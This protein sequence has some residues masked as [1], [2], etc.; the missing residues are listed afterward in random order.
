MTDEKDQ[1]YLT[2]TAYPP[3]MAPVKSVIE[4]DSIDQADMIRK[5]KLE[6]AVKMPPP[7]TTYKGWLVVRG[8]EEDRKIVKNYN[9]SA[10]LFID[11]LEDR[12]TRKRPGG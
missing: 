8:K 3:G 11:D 5:A 4:V 9:A 2:F 6:E 7:A 12:K 1:L 10:R